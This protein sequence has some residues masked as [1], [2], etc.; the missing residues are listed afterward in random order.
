MQRS[1]AELKSGVECLT[2]CF[3]VLVVIDR[4]LSPPALTGLQRVS[5]WVR[6]GRGMAKVSILSV[7]ITAT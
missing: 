2:W 5:Q 4:K 7:T 1:V 3:T 6:G